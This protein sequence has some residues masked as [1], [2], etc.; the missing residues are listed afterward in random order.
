[1][2]R[3][4]RFQHRPARGGSPSSRVPG[5]SRSRARAFRRAVRTWALSRVSLRGSRR[6]ARGSAPEVCV[7]RARVR[8]GAARVPPRRRSGLAPGSSAPAEPPQQDLRR[9]RGDG[10]PRPGALRGDRRR[11]PLAAP[12][13]ARVS[14]S[15]GCGARPGLSA[16]LAAFRGRRGVWDV[17]L[18]AFRRSPVWRVHG[19]G[20][21]VVFRLR[22]AACPMSSH[23]P[24]GSSTR[25]ST[26]RRERRAR[27]R[28]SRPRSSRRPVTPQTSR[29]PTPDG[30]S[31][32]GRARGGARRAR[33]HTALV[34]ASG[35]AASL[36]LALAL[37]E[38]RERLVLP[39]DG[40]YGMRVLA[41]L[42][43]RLEPV[44]VDLQDLDAVGEAL[45]GAPSVLWAG[46]AD[47]PAPARHGS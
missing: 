47:E 30:E 16:E 6:R 4:P 29:P 28:S 26:E 5:G 27:R 19:L 1:M 37:T 21:A 46:D 39:S 40:Y 38:G 45:A 15:V 42:L 22:L 14:V 13:R 25:A 9:W 44:P 43:D 3:K 18:R 31:D 23:R 12:L 8:A 35:Q 10:P 36:A 32:L 17:S 41:E 20:Q 34:F 2:K 7:P 11:A 33:G 24:R